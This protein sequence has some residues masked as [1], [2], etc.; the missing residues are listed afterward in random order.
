MA[1]TASALA[2]T[3]AKVTGAA[4]AASGGYG[5]YL[6]QTD[7]GTRRAMTAYQTFVPT[8]LQYRWMEW[9]VQRGWDTEKGADDAWDALDVQY[10]KPTVERLGELQGMYTKYGQTCAGL[11]NTFSD[12]WIHELRMLEDRVPPR[13]VKVVYKTIEQET[14]RPVDET[15]SSFDPNPLGSASIGQVHKAVLRSTGEPVCVKVQYPDAENLFRSDMKT[16]RTFCE[17]LAPEQVVMLQALEQQNEKELDYIQEAD[18]L[19]EVAAN[20]MA[21]GY[22]PREIVIPKP[23]FATRKLLVMEHLEGPK[24]NDGVTAYFREW[25]QSQ[26]T[27]LEELEKKAREEIEREGIPARY[28]GPS[29]S[30][31]ALY[32]SYL[33]LYDTVANC[34]VALYN[35]TIGS[36]ISS[37]SPYK[38]STVP[39]NT[40]RIIDTLMRVH[41]Y[42]L[43][44]NGVFQADPHGGQFILLPDGRIGCIDYGATKRF[45]RNERLAACVLYAALYRGDAE[46]LFQMCEIAGYKSKYGR[47]DVLLKLLQ[48][49]L[50]SYGKDVTGG[51]NV[52]QFIDELKA[53]DP[54]EEVADNFVMAQFMSIRLRSLALGMNHPVKCSEWWGPMAIQILKEEG[55]PYESWDYDQLVKYKPDISIQKHKFA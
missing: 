39:P 29:A 41:G 37:K 11:N 18:N 24:L 54:W 48:F 15:F 9:K 3:T 31:L 26:G 34:G 40:P 49:G 16:I 45:S 53:A 10:A 43:L 8:A 21:A 19:R 20:M 22:Q 23:I 12:R 38:R 55:L 28:D 42:Q 35:G 44:K 2:R 30:T 51:K 27:T 33:S 5:T 14:G 36:T 1:T 32:K 47:K 17:Y 50:D 25:A 7:E 6:Y 52:Q 4:L 46:V 13:D